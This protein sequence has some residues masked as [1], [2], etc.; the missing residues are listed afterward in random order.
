MAGIAGSQLHSSVQMD[1]FRRRWHLPLRRIP[2]G[3]IFLREPPTAVLQVA[4]PASVDL[5]VSYAICT[6][7]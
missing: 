5:A 4:A 7:V 6:S 1:E 3:P 2:V